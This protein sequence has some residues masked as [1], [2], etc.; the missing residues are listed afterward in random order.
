MN[1]SRLMDRRLLPLIGPLLLFALWELVISAR[2]I[3]PV[4]L[5]PPGETLA[6]VL[7]R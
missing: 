5:P 3:K 2:W 1:A 4:L 7:H 6:T